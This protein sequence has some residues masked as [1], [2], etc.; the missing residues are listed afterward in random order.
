MSRLACGHE[1]RVVTEV[2][3]SD[4]LDWNIP[5]DP[6]EAG[7]RE[8]MVE[9]EG[10][11][12]ALRAHDGEARG[13]DEAEILVGVLTQQTER[14][15]FGL[16]MDED[17]LEALRVLEVIEEPHR[18]RMT[19]NHAQ[20]REVFPITWFVVTSADAP[21]RRARRVRPRVSSPPP[22]T[23]E[24]RGRVA[25]FAATIPSVRGRSS[26]NPTRG[27][28]PDFAQAKRARRTTGAAK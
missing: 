15:C 23:S 9:R 10:M 2:L 16:V 19:A 1:N 13:V 3:R 18:G 20:E 22:H 11:A 21:A 4:L 14:S 12:D 26:I 25:S 24:P 5:G 7:G 6:Q 28:G 27:G 17:P 8:V